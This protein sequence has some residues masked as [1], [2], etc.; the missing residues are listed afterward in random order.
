[1]YFLKQTYEDDSGMIYEK[2]IGSRMF[3]SVNYVVLFLFSLLCMVPFIHI[4]AGSLTTT[5]GLLRYHFVLIPSEFTLE[6]YKYIFSSGSIA[7]SLLI[8]VYITLVGTSFNLLFTVLLAYPLAR[9]H[10]IGKK[11]I[12]FSIILTIVFSPGMIPNFII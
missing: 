6:A 4:I 12:M 2:S 8:T 7:D 9:I 11:V 5:E 3:D 10:V 1:R